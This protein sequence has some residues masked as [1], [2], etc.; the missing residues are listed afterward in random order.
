MK[1]KALYI[2]LRVVSL[3]YTDVSEDAYCLRH[4]GDESTP[5]RLQGAISQKA[6][7]F[8]LAAVRT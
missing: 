6:L 5:T 8:I 1:I 3:E 2:Y 7:I 4:Q